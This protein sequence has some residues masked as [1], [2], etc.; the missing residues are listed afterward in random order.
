MEL[1][2]EG[3]AAAAMLSSLTFLLTFTDGAQQ[4]KHPPN[5][6]TRAQQS[7]GCFSFSGNIND[8]QLT[9]F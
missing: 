2:V 7:K 8:F 9:A 3:C 1:R 4:V 5:F 6:I